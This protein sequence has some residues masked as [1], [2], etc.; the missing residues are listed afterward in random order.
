MWN[1]VMLSTEDIHVKYPEVNMK[2]V[3]VAQLKSQ[4]MTL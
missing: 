4:K 3:V 1:I 2:L